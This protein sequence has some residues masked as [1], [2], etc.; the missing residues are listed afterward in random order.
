MGM[1]SQQEEQ[2]GTQ[3]AMVVMVGSG[4]SLSWVM[5]GNGTLTSYENIMIRIVRAL[6]QESIL[7]TMEEFP[8]QPGE[9]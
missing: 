5:D 1:S 6:A 3:G 2:P 9:P 7:P 4:G 8:D